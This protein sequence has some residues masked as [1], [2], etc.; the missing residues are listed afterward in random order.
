MTEGKRGVVTY[1]FVP[2]CYTIRSEI[3]LIP[4]VF[5]SVGLA[6]DYNGIGVGLATVL[7]GA[8]SD[9]EAERE[10]GHRKD[11]DAV[12]GADALRDAGKA[13][14]ENRIA[15]EEG[16]LGGGLE[17][18]LTPSVGSEQVEGLDGE[19]KGA[20]L[21]ELAEAGAEGDEAVAGDV[22][23]AAD[24]RLGGVVDTVL[25]EAKAVAARI[26]AGRPFHGGALHHDLQV[27]PREL[28]QLLED[29]R[30]LLLVQRPHFRASL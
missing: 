1:L 24:Q 3:V 4:Q 2:G 9:P 14:F 12:T 5:P 18:D 15:I 13:R 7:G 16:H 19:A 17:P 29:G 23:G 28:E 20:A 22:S 11:D 26:V 25:V 10:V 30:R 27:W 6:V 21:C 8:G